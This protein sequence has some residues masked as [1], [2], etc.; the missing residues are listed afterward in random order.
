MVGTVVLRIEHSTVIFPEPFDLQACGLA[1]RV[2]YDVLL[3]T[4]VK[5]LLPPT[6]KSGSLSIGSYHGSGRSFD[7]TSC[8]CRRSRSRSRAR[9]R[10]LLYLPKSCRLKPWELRERCEAK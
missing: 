3:W 5:M 2:C 7:W 9:P 6:Q 4:V 10:F 1:V 8:R